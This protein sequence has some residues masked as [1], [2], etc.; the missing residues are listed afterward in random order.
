MSSIAN[1]QSATVYYDPSLLPLPRELPSRKQASIDIAP[2]FMSVAQ[3]LAVN[4]SLQTN[5]EATRKRIIAEYREEYKKRLVKEGTIPS[6]TQFKQQI[7]A[8]FTLKQEQ[9]SAEVQK[10]DYIDQQYNAYH[11][12]VEQKKHNE[13]TQVKFSANTQVNAHKR[14]RFIVGSILSILFTPLALFAVIPFF[15][16]KIVEIE[17]KTIVEEKNI[18]TKYQPKNKSAWI[19]DE[20][21]HAK[22]VADAPVHGSDEE[23]LRGYY[24]QKRKAELASEKPN[25]S[26][27]NY[28]C[29]IESHMKGFEKSKEYKE[30]QAKIAK[31]DPKLQRLQQKNLANAQTRT[32]VA[33]LAY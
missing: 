14:S 22:N 24:L 29:S 16:K 30:T 25:L 10:D 15:N 2:P 19:R 3:A 6:F 17:Q 9:T 7:H 21:Q 18:H 8:A 32:P 20:V 33:T 5:L 31:L 26:H 27:D 12:S 28:L 13:I 4:G 23:I 1:G 11:A